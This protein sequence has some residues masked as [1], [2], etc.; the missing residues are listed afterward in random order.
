MT[1][2]NKNDTFLKKSESAFRRLFEEAKSRDELNFAFSLSP[3]FRPYTVNTA[4]DAQRAFAEYSEF[5]MTY[6]QDSPIRIRVALAFYSHISE[7]SGFW[8]IPR[9]LLGIIA[10]LKYNMMPFMELVKR[11]GTTEGSIA[12]NAGRIMRALMKYSQEVGY[13]DLAEVFRDAFDVDLRNAYAHADYAL[14]EQ[15]ICVKPRYNG[16]RIVNWEEFALL[17]HKATEFYELLKSIDDEY[18]SSYLTPKVVMGILNDRDPEGTWTIHY[19]S[20][21]RLFSISGQV[22]DTA[23]H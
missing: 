14:L 12:P 20:E 15:G 11:Y 9:N 6:S 13:Q 1:D 3:E 21:T 5:L 10:G 2:Y 18:V 23:K 8:E 19:D 16:E 17:L 7:A 22:S 4:L